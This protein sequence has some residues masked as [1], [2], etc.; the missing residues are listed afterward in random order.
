MDSNS[1]TVSA[2]KRERKGNFRDDEVKVLLELYQQHFHVLSS[3]FSSI[4][5]Q[6]RKTGGVG[7]GGNRRRG[8]IMWARLKDDPGKYR[9]VSNIFI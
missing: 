9:K 8:I 7:M 6:K 3:K 4:V 1:V 5:T 2:P